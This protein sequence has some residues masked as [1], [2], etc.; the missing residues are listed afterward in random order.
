MPRPKKK[1]TSAR[2]NRCC[3]GQSGL[4]IEAGVAPARAP[5]GVSLSLT[6][7][8]ESEPRHTASHHTNSDPS[9][10]MG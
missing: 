5:P 6:E 8:E 7:D 9:N 10:H 2:V 4:S 1:G 3:S